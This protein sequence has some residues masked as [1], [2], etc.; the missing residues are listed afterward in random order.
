MLED[1]SCHILDIAENSAAA[2]AATVTIL[3]EECRREGWLHLSVEDDGRGMD[4]E[5]CA[6]VYDPFFTTRTTRRVGLGIPFL[7]QAAEACDGELTLTS[8]LGEGTTLKASFRLDH[9]DRPPVGDI[10]ATLVTLLAGNPRI[11]WIYRHRV[12]DSEFLLDSQELLAVLEDPD[13][14]RTPAVAEWLRSYIA[15]N[16]EE[17]GA[18]GESIAQDQKS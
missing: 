8:R 14:L 12:D 1:L 10:A 3:L 16:L 18:G 13:M 17:I 6:R 11:R 5:R 9:I 4:E 7:R 2:D 15:E